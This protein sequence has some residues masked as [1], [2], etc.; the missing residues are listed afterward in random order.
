MPKHAQ[1]GAAVMIV[2]FA[3]AIAASIGPTTAATQLEMRQC[4][5]VAGQNFPPDVRVTACTNAMQSL[6]NDKQREPFLVLRSMAYHDEKHYEKALG[7]L[8]KALTINPRDEEALL[9][10]AAVYG[11]QGLYDL[12]IKDLDKAA[13]PEPKD[14]NI[15]NNRASSYAGKQQYK[16]AIRDTDKALAI[17]PRF[18]V[19][20]FTRGRANYSLGNLAEAAADF[21]RLL[22]QHPDFAYPAFWLD[23]AQHRMKQ[24][25]SFAKAAAH[26]DMQKWP[27]PI[28]RLYL[29]KATVAETLAAADDPDPATKLDNICMA[30]FYAAEYEIGRGA[31]DDGVRLLHTAAT[32]CPKSDFEYDATLAELKRLGQ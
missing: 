23:I 21:G 31:A 22:E 7:D 17:N 2:A 20:R 18:F 11:D 30:H 27:A 12:S 28:V 32:V 13:A 9:E 16:L 4:T 25:S 19:A 14:A 15:Y 8:R 1:P 26:F 6:K 3:A 5:D 29:G 24:P 10:R